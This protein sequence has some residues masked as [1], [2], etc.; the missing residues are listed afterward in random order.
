MMGPTEMIPVVKAFLDAAKQA[1][2]DEAG[3]SSGQHRAAGGVLRLLS[4]AATRLCVRRACLSR[5]P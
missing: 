2:P 5:L 3:C 1:V 4:N